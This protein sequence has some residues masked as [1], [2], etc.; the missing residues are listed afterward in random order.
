MDLIVQNLENQ[1]SIYRNNSEKFTKNN[2]LKISL[3]GIG[4]NTLGIGAKLKVTTGDITQIQEMFNTRGFLS[5]V[6]LNLNFGIGSF[7]TIDEVEVT[8]PWIL[9]C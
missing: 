9:I 4:E 1:A 6:D 2:Y 7:K 3:N 5:S 8:W